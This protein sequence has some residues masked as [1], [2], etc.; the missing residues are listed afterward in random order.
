[1]PE[2]DIDELE[3]QNQPTEEVVNTE[4]VEVESPVEETEDDISDNEVETLREQNKKLFARA[5]K[6]EGFVQDKDGNWVKP[7]TKP[8]PKPQ[9]QPSEKQDGFDL[10]DVA[11]LVQ[12]VPVKE[13]RELVKDYANFKKISLEKALGETVIQAELKDRAEKRQTAEATNTGTQRRGTSKPSPDQVMDRAAKG[14]LPENPEDLADA[15]LANMK[16]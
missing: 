6:A 5:K 1:M 16:K 8:Q 14:Q 15:W 3:S 2:E 7:A 11:V 4:E 10:E 9:A 13:D 12:K